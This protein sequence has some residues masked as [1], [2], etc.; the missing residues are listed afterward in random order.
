MSQRT[1]FVER[2]TPLLGAALFFGVL[3]GY[4]AW[5]MFIQGSN[6]DMMLGFFDLTPTHPIGWLTL[7]G[8]AFMVGLLLWRATAS[9]MRIVMDGD[10]LRFGYRGARQVRRADVAGVDLSEEG[11]VR[12]RLVQPVTEEVRQR[13]DLPE[14]HD[15]VVLL[16]QRLEGPGPLGP[17]VERW[18]QPGGPARP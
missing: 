13:A 7:V 16:D 11:V 2:R 17:A 5:S 1:E 3:G 14:D 15:E 6:P 18:Y 8:A 4:T 9:R 12:L 10:L